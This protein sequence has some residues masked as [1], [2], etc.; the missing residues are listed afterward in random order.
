MGGEQPGATVLIL[1]LLYSGVFFC[2]VGAEEVLRGRGERMEPKDL[3]HMS[4]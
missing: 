3:E 1:Y 4:R 2:L